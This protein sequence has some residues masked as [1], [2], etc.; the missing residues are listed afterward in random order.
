MV[1]SEPLEHGVIEHALT[2]HFTRVWRCSFVA[3]ID[4][5][6]GMARMGLTQQDYQWLGQAFAN[7]QASL[8][9]LHQ[10]IVA[11]HRGDQAAIDAIS[12]HVSEQT[13]RLGA[14]IDS[15]SPNT[16]RR[17]FMSTGTTGSPN[18]LATI[19]QLV[20]AEDTVADSV[21]ALL[22]G[23]AAQVKA[24]QPN[25]AAIDALAADIT[26]KTKALSDAVVANTPAAPPAG[27]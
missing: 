15:V 9:G 14:A 2:S 7:V 13:E 18:T 3:K 25:Q 16:S 19:Q 17:F 5:I 8:H 22:T 20:T 26:A 4:Q 11:Y 6:A 27:P 21:I 12:A 24:L 1:A 23:F 10:L